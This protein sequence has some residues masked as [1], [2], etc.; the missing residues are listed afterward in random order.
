MRGFLHLGER[1]EANVV[2]LAHF[3]ERPANAHVT[4]QSPAAI[5]RAFKGGD[6]GAHWEAPGDCLAASC[7]R[8]L[9]LSREEGSM[10]IPSLAGSAARSARHPPEP[11][12]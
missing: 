8:R 2:G 3:L 6:G 7:M 1:N 5:G 4:R 9:S 10:P 11:L 12:P